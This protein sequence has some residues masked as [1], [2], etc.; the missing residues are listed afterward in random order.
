MKKNVLVVAGETSGDMHAAKVIELLKQHCP[1]VEFWG[2]GGDKLAEQGVEIIQ[3][4][5]EMDVI[6]VVEVLKKYPFFRRIF[7]NTLAEAEKRQPDLVFTVDYPGFNMR[8]AKQ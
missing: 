8:L 7:S 6:G 1:E 3:P 4:I 5:D 2:I